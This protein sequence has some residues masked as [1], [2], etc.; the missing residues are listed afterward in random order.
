MAPHANGFDAL[1]VEKVLEDTYNTNRPRGY[2]PVS[3][4]LSLEAQRN[5]RNLARYHHTNLY[6]YLTDILH[7]DLLK[8]RIPPTP[9]TRLRLTSRRISL[10]VSK[11]VAALLNERY[12]LHATDPAVQRFHLLQHDLLALLSREIANI[13]RSSSCLCGCGG[14]IAPFRNERGQPRWILEGHSYY[15]REEAN[16]RPREKRLL[17]LV[18]EA[19][20]PLHVSVL[21]S[22]MGQDL[23]GI[24][25]FASELVGLG[26]LRKAGDGYYDLPIPQNSAG[27]GIS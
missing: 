19:G 24:R 12:L 23:Q 20:E 11:R 14:T 21:A 4:P 16:Q 8:E 17:S 6:Y 22:A 26:L 3:F 10:F 2:V 5:L 9:P 27:P 7:P 18:Q 13:G 1:L 25:N 15:L